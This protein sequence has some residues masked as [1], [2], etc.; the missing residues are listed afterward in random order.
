MKWV[1]IA[2]GILIVYVTSQW[3]VEHS[4]RGV[5]GTVTVFHSGVQP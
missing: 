4:H 1:Y 3:I 2:A 5:D